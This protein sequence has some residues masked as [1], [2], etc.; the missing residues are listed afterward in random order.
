MQIIDEREMQKNKE[1]QKKN[2]WNSSYGERVR[3]K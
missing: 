2:M 1:R 3:A